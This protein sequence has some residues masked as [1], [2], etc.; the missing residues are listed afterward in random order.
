MS[1]EYSTVKIKL[2]L[3]AAKGNAAKVRQIIIAEAMQDSKLLKELVAP[4]M[5]GIVA[6]AVGRVASGDAD[7]HAAKTS[8][9]SVSETNADSFGIDIL[10]TIAGGDTAQFGQESYA[11]PM[12]KHEAS[13][14]HIDAIKQMVKKSQGR[15]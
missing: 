2:A 3:E 14:A 13:K 15:T 5:A 10:K 7:S 1:R 11:R 4:H 8:K 9:E 6:H 12:K